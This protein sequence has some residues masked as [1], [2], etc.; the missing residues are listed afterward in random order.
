ML[1]EVITFG[2]NLRVGKGQATVVK[3]NAVDKKIILDRSS[4]GELYDVEHGTVRRNNFV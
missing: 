1:Y 2:I 4:S 3:Y